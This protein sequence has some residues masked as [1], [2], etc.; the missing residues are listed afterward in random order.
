MNLR[1]YISEA[2]DP[3]R[4]LAVE[5]FLFRHI[6]PD[7]MTL[8]LW[9]N[10][11]TI[12]I[13]RN[14]DAWRECRVDAFE[15]SGGLLVRR[16]SGG[17][18]V[19]HDL[20]NQNFSFLTTASLYDVERQT[21]VIGAAAREFGIETFRDGRND[22]LAGR[23]K[24]SGNAF[25]R[26]GESCLHHGTILI[27]SDLDAMVRYL[28]PSPEKLAGRGVTS[29]NSRV[30]NLCELSPIL[31]ADRMRSALVRAFE[32]I[33]GG[34]AE[35]II[36]GE[37]DDREIGELTAKYASA[38]WRLGEAWAYTARFAKRLSFGEIDARLTVREG[39]I[40]QA[41]IFSDAMDSQFVPIICGAL[42]GVRY[43]KAAIYGA[44]MGVRVASW[45]DLA[46]IAAF[47][48]GSVT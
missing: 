2:T 6:Q 1:L 42:T 14:Q 46:E 38:E 16:L 12:V 27:H 11:N 15:R 19:Y 34:T 33:Y 30:V 45:D 22:I 37:F 8:Y 23:R 9:Q 28:N 43:E 48:A 17:G 5:E 24:F 29:V 25:Y 47:L 13:G 32:D 7:E 20:G 3:R 36:T 35:P 39:V 31:T 44:V 21:E 10:H 41:Q 4:N 18:A 40:E 26:S